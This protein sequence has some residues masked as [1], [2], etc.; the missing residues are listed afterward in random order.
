MKAAKVP[1]FRVAPRLF[2]IFR[3][4]R[5]HKVLGVVRGID[6]LPPP[7]AV[8]ETFE[9]LGVAFHKFGQV[10]AMRTDILPSAYTDEL[11]V[12]HDQMPAMDFETV[13]R[14]IESTLD[15]TM[16]E[17]FSSFSESPIAA[18]TIAQVHEATLL[19][20][21]H[22]AVKVQRPGLAGLIRTDIAA[23][24]YMAELGEALFPSLRMYD[25]TV[26][27]REFERS[28]TR[29][30]DFTR[31][32][33]SIV[34]FGA[35]LKDVPDLWIPGIVAEYSKESILMLEFSAGMR[36]DLYAKEH[37]E[38]MARSINTLVSLMLHTIF[39]EGIF[40]ADPHPGNVF[41]LPDG[42]LS[43]LDFG[44]TGD[45]DEPMR[46]SLVLLLEAVVQKDGKM[47]TEAYLEMATPTED[48]DRAGMLLDI[49]AA[50]YEVGRSDQDNVSI[51]G[52][53]DALLRAGTRNGV[54]N[55]AEIILLVRAFVILESMSMQLAPDHNYVESFRVEI[56]RLTAQ[57]FSPE[58]IQRKAIKIAREIERLVEQAPGDV[59]LVLRR[60]AEGH[61]LLQAPG[62]EALGGRVSDNLERLAGAIASAAL[63]VGGAMVLVAR[64][65]G[66][67]ETAGTVMIVLGFLSMLLIRLGTFGRK[68]E[69]R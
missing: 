13:R 4:L 6:H 51:G 1:L 8:L 63:L 49:K 15:T 56:S 26:A 47:A 22:V 32:A 43:L 52:A 11:K 19:D 61:G 5:R 39:E 30:L 20:G 45:L 68:R 41:V 59:R 36:I 57:H 55:P 50:L 31:E 34:L 48:I 28:L 10:L 44:N 40:H 14:T 67:L 53:F 27:V 65:G 24:M 29:E 60:V 17:L 69:R 33:A 62:L 12:L 37:P 2:Q 54:R 46:E 3:I 58:R 16:P 7:K 42:R 21:R 23:M 9:E 66:W 25:A 38:A 64:L 35:A 18:A